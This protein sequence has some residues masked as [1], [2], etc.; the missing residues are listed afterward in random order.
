MCGSPVCLGRREG[1]VPVVII[2]VSLL[3]TVFY[4]GFI[5]L[6]GHFPSDFWPLRIV[7]EAGKDL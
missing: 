1:G 2:L 6:F 4:I 3:L 5:P 7:K